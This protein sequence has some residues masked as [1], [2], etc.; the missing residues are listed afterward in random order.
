MA[1]KITTH[2]AD[3]LDRLL[4]QYKGKS[5][6]EGV[7]E[8]YA[9]QIQDNEDVTWGLTA[10]LAILTAIGVQLD[11]IGTIVIQDRL[12]F[13]DTF[14][15]SLLLAKIGENVSQSDPERIIDVVKLLTGATLVH[16]LENW[17]AAYDISID[18]EIDPS[19]IDFQYSRIDRVDPAAVRLENLICFDP[20]EAFAFA[21]GVGDAEGFGDLTDA[22]VGGLF[23]KINV[24]TEPA[25]AFAP[26][27]GQTSA[28]EGFGT[29]EDVFVGGILS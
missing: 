21:G 24:R 15:R 9:E 8:A 23:A 2:V 7:I 3:A 10:D 27:P 28:D 1:D 19:L 12:G 20:D 26:S 25:F 11:G 18:V 13:S 22:G 6:V 14:Y 16:Y 4:E 5:R 29:L 17:P